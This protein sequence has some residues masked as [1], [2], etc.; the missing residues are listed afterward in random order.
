M[1]RLGIAFVLITEKPLDNLRAVMIADGVEDA[2]PEET[3][4]AWQYLHDSGLGYALKGHFAD[5]L[6]RMLGEG[7]IVQKG[8]QH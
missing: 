3:L 8:A 2:T 6:G 1:T 7:E 5:T 4:E